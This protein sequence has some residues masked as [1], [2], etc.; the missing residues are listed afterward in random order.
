MIF[1][2][3]KITPSMR[4][5]NA[6]LLAAASVIAPMGAMASDDA[7]TS[8]A[9]TAQ[10]QNTVVQLGSSISLSVTATNATT[11]QWRKNGVAID[12]ATSATLSIPSAAATD[13]GVYDVVVGNGTDTVTS[14][15][16]TVVVRNLPFDAEGWTVPTPSPDSRVVY[17]SSSEGNDSNDGLTPATPKAT[18]AAGD[19]LIRD[20]FPD[21]LLL[22]CGDTFTPAAS[23]VMGRWKNGRSAAEPLVMSCYGTG[24]RPVIKITDKFIDHNGQVRN[25]QAFIGLEIYK[26]NS[27]PASPDFTNTSGAEGFRL[28]GGGDSILIEDCR[29]RFASITIQTFG[30]T[31]YTNVR[32]ARNIV[33]DAWVKDSYITE[34][35]G[36]QGL[37]MSGVDGY[38]LEENFFDHNGWNETVPNA[39]ANQYNHNIYIQYDNHGGGLVR[40]NI[41]TRGAA[42]GIQARSGGIVERNLFVLN[43]VALNVGGVAVP[44]HPDVQAFPNAALDNVV[45]NGR[46]MDPANSDPPRT[47]AV[48]GIWDPGLITGVRVDGNIVANRIDDGSNSAYVGRANMVFGSNISYQWAADTDTDDPS[49][50]HPQ[51]DLGDFHVSIGGADSTSAYLEWERNRP[52]HQLPWDMTAYAA[53][54]YIRSGFNYAPVEGY[55]D[56]DG[57][58]VGDT[59]PVITVA[60]LPAGVTGASY[61]A[62]LL[63]SGGNGTRTWTQTAGTLP[64]GLSLSATG[65]IS[66]NPTTVGSYTFTVQVSDGDANTAP[67]DADAAEFTIDVTEPPNHVPVITTTVIPAALPNAAY[68][69]ALQGTGGDGALE[70]SLD[71]GALPDGMTLSSAGVISGTPAATGSYAF[72]VRLA[73][74]D[75]ITG[76]ADEATRE[77][78]LTVNPPGSLTVFTSPAFTNTSFAP[79]TG[80]F[81]VTFLAKP[82]S[83]A[84]NTVMALANGPVTAFSGAA[85]IVRF[86]DTGTIDARNGGAY[87]AVATIP[88]AA[89][90]TYLFRLVVDVPTHTYSAYVTPPG[91][92]ELTIGSNYAFRTEQNAVPKLDTFVVNNGAP[93]GGWVEITNFKVTVPATV[94]L[95]NLTQTYD[96]APKP[97]AITTVPADLPVNVTYDGSGTPPTNAGTYAVV[98]TIVDPNYTGSASG[99]LTIEPAGAAIVLD[100]LRQTYDGTPK[101]VTATTLPG[102]LPVTVTY[103]GSTTPPMLPGTY[104]V[105]ATIADAN[106]AGAA[107]DTLTIGI[108]ALVRHAPTLNGGLDGSLQVLDAEHITLNGSAWISGDLLVP[109]TPLV[110][111]NGH[112]VYAGTIDAAG[113]SAPSGNYTVTLNG[114]ALL[115]HVVR[116]VDPIAL[117]VVDAPP[118]PAGTVDVT[119][120]DAGQNVGDWSSVRNLT[121]NGGAGVRAV[122]PGP[123][124][125]LTA[126]GYS[127]FI[128]GVAG[129]SEPAAYALQGLAINGN[130]SV[131]VV[132][133]VVLTLASGVTLNGNVGSP[134]HPEWF[135][136][137]V[138]SGGVTLNGN[139]T[140]HGSVIAPSGAVV[141][142]GSSTVH[143]EVS[144]DRLTLNGNAGL[145]EPENW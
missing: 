113:A 48:W 29:V 138:A 143:G 91:G 135:V 21:H 22:K 122:P 105:E 12:D 57:L 108:T 142:N 82:S 10:P 47:A 38:V 63:A 83:A 51:A 129:A 45:L 116:R 92:S 28:V 2:P 3:S 73:D 32:L 42:H 27:D 119:L 114:N 131:Q 68:T 71:S 136:L 25:Y 59:A 112:P 23:T 4:I 55:Y 13:T 115:R 20:G 50:P 132:G 75:A 127:G 120:N 79:Q 46:L 125:V 26:S 104:D 70:W 41:I 1:T 64:P 69:F 86:F 7:S 110:K 19:A 43:A 80:T 53:I 99:T 6:I 85:A 126:N 44:T 58:Q 61:Y 106:H 15:A 98:A 130:A 54:N 103:G 67:E 24:A 100:G 60:S 134:E 102:G 16:A 93:V 96:G 140:L 89:N 145:V 74:G 35:A 107:M 77:L 139:V 101:P 133:P 81:T 30:G 34:G 144:S 111:L 52:V 8:L 14:V 141:I 123:Y 78:V 39:G 118:S 117:P 62:M 37:Y 137:R 124:G 109:G 66:G 88:Y 18:I 5:W 94:V 84:S 33:L 121:L 56:Y 97:V 31:P 17:V 49:W 128:L 90:Q 76:S 9:I 11:Y 36:I 87:T 95:G 65:V 72:V 40:G